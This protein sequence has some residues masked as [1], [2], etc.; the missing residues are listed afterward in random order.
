MN[1]AETTVKPARL[2]SPL[3][4]L[5]GV[6][7]GLAF[8]SWE[9]RQLGRVD[10]HTDFTRFH[11]MIS[12][13]ALYEPTVDEMCAIV[14]ARCRPDQVLVIVGGNSILL[15]VGQPADRMWTR[16][17]QDELGAGYAVVNLAMR[18]A[19]PND[20]GA[21]VAETLRKEFPRQIYIANQS[22][23]PSA[24]PIGSETYRFVLYDA[25]FK[26][27]LLPWKPRTGALS[28]LSRSLDYHKY[29]QADL[30]IGGVLDSWF[31]FHNLWNWWSF[32]HHFTFATPMMPHDPEAHWPRD[33]F[34]DVENDFDAIP[35][36]SRFTPQVVA[37][38]L[39]LT[40]RA[41]ETFYKESA[42]G[43]WTRNRIAYRIFLVGARDEFP[44]PVKSRTLILIGRN[45]PYYT[46]QVGPEIR[47]RDELA[48]GDTVSGLK[49]LK[50]EAMA[51]GLDFSPEDYGDRSHLTSSG[52][53]KLAAA[54]APQIRAMAEKLHY[55]D[56]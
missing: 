28:A 35:F 5:L 26:G 23:F 49:R 48:I 51:Y 29:T 10:W 37:A 15:G 25:Y 21:L 27:Y 46:S 6:A 55:L 1:A 18:G 44:D 2:L 30:E 19:L 39:D 43:T 34:E 31:Y 8:L 20:A 12:P 4:L 7:T 53:A 16:R 3:A 13:E 56:H 38:D 22:A 32:T 40:R 42:D 50:Y 47:A 14:R 45:S 54:V 9:G 52:G 41:T 36:E 17:L 11:P 24:G 33:K